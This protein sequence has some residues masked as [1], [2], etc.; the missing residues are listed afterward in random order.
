M[1][2]GQ[3]VEFP[4]DGPVSANDHIWT[5]YQPDAHDLLQHVAAQLPIGQIQALLKQVLAQR[6][7][8]HCM[9]SGPWAARVVHNAHA[10]RS[11]HR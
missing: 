9:V 10:D 8:I 2:G 4:F 11:S 3:R 6:F 5:P 7:F 1:Q